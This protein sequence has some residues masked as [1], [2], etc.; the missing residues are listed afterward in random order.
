[1]VLA[2]CFYL[3]V[4]VKLAPSQVLDLFLSLRDKK[5]KHSVYHP[6][7]RFVTRCLTAKGND[8][9]EEEQV[10]VAVMPCACIW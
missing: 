10:C 7:S 8:E 3:R 9:E 6:V 4:T 5:K 2:V 1:M